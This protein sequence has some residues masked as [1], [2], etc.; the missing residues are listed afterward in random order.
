MSLYQVDIAFPAKKSANDDVYRVEVDASGATAA[1]AK[2]FFAL[3]QSLDVRGAGVAEVRRL[4]KSVT[5]SELLS[6]R[7]LD[8]MMGC[9]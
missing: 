4:A 1:E 7:Q 2:A 5:V 3:C 8:Q 9:F 6:I